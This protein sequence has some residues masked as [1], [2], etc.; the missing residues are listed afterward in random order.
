M[1]TDKIIIVGGGSAGWM[2]A[3]TLIRLFPNKKITL[4][5][6]KNVPV[7]GVGESTLAA[8]N[9]WLDLVGIKDEDFMKESDATYKLSIKFTDFYKKNSAGFHYPFG[10]PD[11]ST[12]AAGKNT[13]YFKKF[14][15]PLVPYSDY[16]RFLYPS[17]ALVEHNTFG[18][19]VNGELGNFDLKKQSAYHFDAIKFG[20]VLKEKICI[21]EGVKY[22]QDDI[23]DALRDVRGNIVSLNN[24]YAADLYIDCTGFQSILLEKILK[25]KFNSY[26]ELLPNDTALVFQVPYTDKEKRLVA[27]TH[28]TALGNGWAWNIPSWKRMGTGYIYSSKYTDEHNAYYEMK[29]HLWSTLGYDIE[30]Q[31]SEYRKINMKVGL[32]EEIFHKNVIAIGLSAGFIEPLESNGLFTV[33]KFLIYLARILHSEELNQFDKDGFNYK[34]KAEFDIFAEFVALHYYLSQRDDTKYWRDLTNKSIK[35]LKLLP[36]ADIDNQLKLKIYNEYN[37]EHGIH[38]IGTGLRQLP[39]DP[40]HIKDKNNISDL[41][42]FTEKHLLASI[43]GR[44]L[45]RQGWLQTAKTKP[46]LLDVL[47]KIHE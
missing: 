28:C 36:D 31:N 20:Q 42:D 1:R 37:S 4:I 39:I 5:E 27:Y 21:P 23:K 35:N 17:L 16:A 26:N 24:K 3:T 19:N 18:E 11:E 34:C 47:K 8:F 45:Q 33:H 10:R 7:V 22:I 13:W 9:D 38:C 32:H 12:L 41:N 25:V 2:T 14:R 15:D 43:K 44:D 46:K 29:Q 6:S 40:T 30:A